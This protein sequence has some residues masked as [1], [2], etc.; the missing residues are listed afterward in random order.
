MAQLAASGDGDT[1]P[2][3]PARDTQEDK[4]GTVCC[5]TNVRQQIL[6]WHH[7]TTLHFQD[8]FKEEAGGTWDPPFHWQSLLNSLPCDSH[9]PGYHGGMNLTVQSTAQGITLSVH[10]HVQF[11]FLMMLP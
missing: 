10:S 3:P 5:N 9:E 11:F 8:K 1:S 2:F 4:L 6:S 7:L